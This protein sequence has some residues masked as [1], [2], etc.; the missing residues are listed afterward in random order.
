MKKICLFYGEEKLLIREEINILKEKIVPDY[1]EAINFIPLDGKTV[2]EDEI[3]NAC[4]I[5]PMLEEEKLVVVYD[6]RFF[7]SNRGKKE[8]LPG[9]KDLLLNGLNDIPDFTYLIF[10]CEKP[11]KRKKLYKFL[12]SHGTLKEFKHL[13]LKNKAQWIKNRATKQGKDMDLSAAYYL[14]EYT[15][16]LYQADNELS[17]IIAFI[18]E[19]QKIEQKDTESIFYKT[20]EGSIFEMMDFIGNKNPTGALS[21]LEHLIFQGEKGIVILFMISKH[22]MDLLS[23]KLLSDHSF[24]EIRDSLGLHPFVLK[25]ALAQSKNFT[26]EE[27]KRSLKLSQKLDLD[28][29][30][31]KIDEK[32]GIELLITAIS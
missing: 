4:R 12:K 21:I 30:R 11:D 28:L 26:I 7:D 2:S 1:L 10:T 32:I 20:L 25:K 22:I 13:T 23:V 18:G 19:R 16:D 27:L 15:K 24:N 31:G 17:K 3:L 9:I 5:A 14:A 6:A 8:E 29:K